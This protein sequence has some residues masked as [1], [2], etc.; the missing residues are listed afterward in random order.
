MLHLKNNEICH[1]I[2]WLQ[3]QNLKSISILPFVISQ[4]FHSIP[5]F[6]WL[7]FIYRAKFVSPCCWKSKQWYVCLSTDA[8]EVTKTF[9][10]D[11]L[12]NIGFSG[13]TQIHT[14]TSHAFECWWFGQTHLHRCLAPAHAHSSD[15]IETRAA[16]MLCIAYEDDVSNA[17]L[18]HA[19]VAFSSLFAF[20]SFSHCSSS[21]LFKCNT[22]SSTH[23]I[24]LPINECD[25]EH[26][27]MRIP[28]MKHTDNEQAASIRTFHN[29]MHNDD[30]FMIEHV[31]CCV[32]E[33]NRT[34]R[35]YFEW[36]VLLWTF[37]IVLILS[38]CW[39]NMKTRFWMDCLPFF[40]IFIFS[41]QQ[42]PNRVI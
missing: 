41:C 29:I 28:R 22:N 11:N 24:I 3:N 9:G 10:F 1:T 39:L 23:I 20:L 34:F 2:F 33:V 14:R 12:L 13:G 31:C 8:I 4:I 16:T 40:Y 15:T 38:F 37:A 26:L 5:I 6:I 27:M 17:P 7:N 19:N 18:I 36:I 30:D 32:T 35:W 42:N 25:D 21:L